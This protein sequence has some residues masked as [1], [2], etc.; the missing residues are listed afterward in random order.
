MPRLSFPQNNRV[1]EVARTL[2]AHHA[3]LQAQ[4][5]AA[6]QS[7]YPRIFGRLEYRIEGEGASQPG[8][9]VGIGIQGTLF[10]GFSTAAKAK[11]ANAQV[12][13]SRHRPPS[14]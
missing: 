12:R 11:E 13:H 1:K 5:S 7:V 8:F 4:A 2:D 9:I 6:R 10:D 14:C 3:A